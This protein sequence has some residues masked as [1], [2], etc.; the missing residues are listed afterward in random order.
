MPNLNR[1]ASLDLRLF[2]W[3][4]ALP[5]GTGATMAEMQEAM[6]VD[7]PQLISNALTRLRRGNLKDPSSDGFLVRKPIRYDTTTRKY[8]DLSKITPDKV[9]AQVPGSILGDQV[10]QLLTRAL[11]LQSALG[12]EGLALSASQYLE[13]DDIRELLAQLPTE[14]MWDAHGVLQE[15]AKARHLLMVEEILRPTVT[16]LDSTC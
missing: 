7:S 14:K 16:L 8:Y 3:W 13:H 2:L 9:A 10:S 12:T 6:D 15:L 5:P 11:T 4:D 1:P